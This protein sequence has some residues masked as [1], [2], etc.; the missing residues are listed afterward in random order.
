MSQP[1]PPGLG[2]APAPAPAADALVAAEWDQ[3]CP[4]CARAEEAAG[5]VYAIGAVRPQFPSL[6]VEREFDQLAGEE[7][8]ARPQIDLVCDLLGRPENE[9]LAH[10]MCWVFATAGG[11]EFG[12]APAATVPVGSLVA[13]ARR[14]QISFVAGYGRPGGCL[15]PDAVEV[16]PVQLLTFTP[17]EFRANLLR[18]IAPEP[19]EHDERIVADLF[20]R[21]RNR[22]QNQGATPGNRAINYLA[23]RAP[24]IYQ[25]VADQAA[26]GAALVAIDTQHRHSASRN[27]VDVRFVF[28]SRRAD[29]VSRYTARVDVTEVFP[30][31]VAPLR[32]T[33]DG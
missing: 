12:V 25:L 32:Q 13:A 29:L 18:A 21:V 26:A 16:T 24:A 9:Y 20:D 5:L 3:T 22:A 15:G 4:G 19:G 17:E 27:V 2:N 10:Q 30:F 6:G 1:P 31:L 7:T 33:F 11:D 14:D 23:L 8:A 28:R